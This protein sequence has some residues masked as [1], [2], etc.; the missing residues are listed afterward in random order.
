M[1]ATEPATKTF[2]L[3]MTFGADRAIVAD[4]PPEAVPHDDV[5]TERDFL[6]RLVSLAEHDSPAVLAE[7]ALALVA[8]RAGATKAYLE[9]GEP[10]VEPA[11]WNASIGIDAP[12]VADVK[13]LL[14]TTIMREALSSGRLVSTS[15]AASDVRFRDA[16]SVR[17]NAIEE[18]LC[19]PFGQPSS[20]LVYLQGHVAGQRFPP[21]ARAWA[22]RFARYLAPVARRVVAL[23]QRS[24]PD[25]TAPFR[26]RLVGSELLVGKSPALANT[27]RLAAAVAAFE[28]PVLITGPSGT[29]K[30]EL[31][32]LIAL[33]SKRA[34]GPFIALNCAAIPENLLESEL[35]GALQG[36]FSGA[37]RRI[38][39]KVELASGGTLFLDEVGELSPSAQSKLLQLLQDGIYWP[40]G[41]TKP[42]QADVRIMAATNADLTKR[43]ADRAFREDLLYRLDVMAIAVPSLDE[44]RG[45]IPLLADRL[46]AQHADR[47]GLGDVSFTL[48]ARQALMVAEWPGN[49]RQ[50][51]NTVLAAAIRAY[52][53]GARQIERAHCFPTTASTHTQALWQDAMRDF[54]R[55]LL[56]DAIERSDGNVTLAAQSLGIARSYAFELVKALGLRDARP[57]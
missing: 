47:H 38:V 44:R 34:S 3:P 54:Q 22:E 6:S 21:E 33:S 32:R 13:R 43:V 10:G 31:A 50:L 56:K 40:L 4:M 14:S 23:A 53:E 12:K 51:I 24:A 16:P 28:V 57:S 11:A 26:A 46:L 17:G 15:S 45:D 48:A 36:S 49:V 18:V 52:S 9:I 1:M 37:T 8:E 7:E 30:S 42:G 41:A 5:R 35:F 27:L 2:V 55:Q 19:V 25:P 20:G 39:G 29:G